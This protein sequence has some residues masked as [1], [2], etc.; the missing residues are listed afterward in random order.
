MLMAAQST[1]T[2]AFDILAVELNLKFQS[3]MNIEQSSEIKFSIGNDKEIGLISA[4]G[5]FTPNATTNLLIQAVKSRITKPAN[6]LDLGCGTGVV[7]IA[8]HLQGLINSP[9]CASDLSASAVL[10]SRENLKR[11]G[12][13]AEVRGG[14]LFEPWQ[15]KKFDVIVD[16][17]SGIAQGVADV[18]PW[19][20][21]VPCDTGKDGTDLVVEIIR[22]APKHLNDGGSFFFPVL[23]LSNV[24]MLLQK[25]RENFATVERVGRQDWPLPAELKVHMPLL[26]KLSAEGSIKLEEKFGMVLCYTEVYFA[27]NPYLSN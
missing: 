3:D 6:L 23:S 13:A 12:C 21:G 26:R 25:A 5:V 18:S 17:I 7:G 22:N 15:G 4:P 8:L 14:S 19:F 20:Q 9:L 16:D 10:C 11:Y 27:A 1:L 24:D 2:V